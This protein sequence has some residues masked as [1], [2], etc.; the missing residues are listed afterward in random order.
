[1]V[2]AARRHKASSQRRFPMCSIPS[3]MARTRRLQREGGVSSHT[4]PTEPALFM[5]LW[6][7]YKGREAA[8]P[9]SQNQ[10]VSR[11][12]RTRG[13]GSDVGKRPQSTYPLWE[14]CGD[15]SA[16]HV[17]STTLPK[18]PQDP[19]GLLDSGWPKDLLWPLCVQQWKGCRV[20][21]VLPSSVYASSATRIRSPVGTT[22]KVSQGALGSLEEA[23]FAVV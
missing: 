18:E 21:Q 2:Q 5:C 17:H 16:A 14:C 8:P 3:E 23:V 15:Q 19:L 22:T 4:H 6:A 9:W 10:E 7:G 11:A 12:A 13:R 20:R 1:M